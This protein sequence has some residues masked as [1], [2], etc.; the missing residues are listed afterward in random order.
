MGAVLGLC[1][2]AQVHFETLEQK[3]SWSQVFILHHKIDSSIFP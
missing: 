2:A 1:S 3:I